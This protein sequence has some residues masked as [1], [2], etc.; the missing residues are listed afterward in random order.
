VADRRPEIWLVRHGETEW[1]R[2][3]RHTGRTDIELTE[4]GREQA[5]ALRPALAGHDFT[6]VI[7]SPLSRALETCRLALPSFAIEP[8]EALLEWDYGEYEGLT[9]AEIR[10][11]R[12]GWVLW[13][14]GC[15]GGEAAEEV[16]K[17]VDPL[18]AELLQTKS[19]VALFAHG[20]VLRVLAARWLGLRP[21]DGAL[22]ALDTGTLSTLG[23]EH[24]TAVIRRWNAQPPSRP[25]L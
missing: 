19:D 21:A 8:S 12:P 4:H 15:P 5:A 25:A 2:I 11:R 13:R 10:K 14:D 22:L 23:W 3:R 20:H 1:S 6:R 18:V 17:R 7:S 24:A 9:S 16:G